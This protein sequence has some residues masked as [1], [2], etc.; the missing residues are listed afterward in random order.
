MELHDVSDVVRIGVNITYN[1][2]S[3]TGESPKTVIQR[4]SDL[5]F[6]DGSSFGEVQN[7]LAMTET[8]KINLPGY[9]YY[10][11]GQDGSEEEYLVRILNT[12]TYK[13]VVDDWHRFTKEVA[14][15]VWDED[16]TTHT[17]SKS[18]A[19]FVRRIKS[20]VNAIFGVLQ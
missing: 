17:I 20:V 18:A 5:L 2:E 10:D 19:W 6:F 8:D 3:V 14:D 9:Y 7:E 1:R 16:L 15:A 4:R 12:G 11:F 13:F